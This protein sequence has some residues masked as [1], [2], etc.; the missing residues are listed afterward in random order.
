MFGSL[1]ALGSPPL[2]QLSEA[3]NLNHSLGGQFRRRN[4]F[5]SPQGRLKPNSSFFVL[6]KMVGI[7]FMVRLLE[8]TLTDGV[9]IQATI[10]PLVC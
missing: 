3:E 9:Q 8:R 10:A 1:K 2:F 6:A 4:F 5:G 7:F